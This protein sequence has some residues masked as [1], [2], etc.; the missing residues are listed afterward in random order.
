MSIKY[1]ND[2]DIRGKKLLI[3][4]D[5]NVPLDEMGNITDDTRIRSVLPTINYALD[6]EAKVILASHMGR[7]NGKIDK[8]L[9]LEPVARRLKRLLGKDVLMA[10]ECIG[11]DVEKL[12]NN[13]DGDYV[14]LLENLRF[15]IGEER[16]EDIFAKELSK[17]A[18][19]Y[20]NDAFAVSHRKNA[21]VVAIT[22]FFNEYGAGFLMKKE[23]NYF[24][25]AMENPARPL[26][27][28]IGGAKV[29]NKLVALENL[30]KKVD[31]M[32]V[33]GGM[34]FTFLKA[35]GYDVGKSLVEEKLVG[36]ALRV[37][38][39]AKKRDV[40][41]YLPVDCV[42]ADRFESKA[43]TKI[44][45][46]QEIPKDW[47]GLDIGPASTV[48]FGEVLQNARTIIWNGPMGVFEMDAFSRGTFAM[49]SLVA[50][51]HALKIVGGGDTDVA[52]NKVGELD[53]MSYIS[54]GGGAFIQLLEGKPLPGIEAL[55]V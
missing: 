7:P 2:I 36:T 27:A 16:N 5:F 18:E 6:E 35:I 30:I 1:I 33:G 48:L 22:K 38:D 34:A 46:V 51:S 41:F 20:I 47:M 25:R 40:K 9:S 15:H 26:V 11:D 3:R 21:S 53:S 39:I 4:V 45:T 13:I 37:L 44:T 55:R 28:V 8:S 14:V 17:L 32:I 49:V 50:R 10:N 52:V 12:V 43:E 23:L 54:T 31:K 19:V 42:I 29:S 24:T